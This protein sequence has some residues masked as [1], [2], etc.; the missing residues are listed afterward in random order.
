MLCSLPP[1]GALD[2]IGADALSRQKTLKFTAN[3]RK[4]DSNW[5]VAIHR[6]GEKLA[7]TEGKDAV[8][9]YILDSVQ[10]GT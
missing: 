7:L 3:Q 10:G 4:T 2:N 6:E 8:G 1:R 9:N 5:R